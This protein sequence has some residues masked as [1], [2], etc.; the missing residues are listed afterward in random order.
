[1]KQVEGTIEGTITT[2]NW[3]AFCYLV[4]GNTYKPLENKNCRRCP[5]TNPCVKKTINQKWRQL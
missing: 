1:M 3:A 4:T 5:Y 2:I